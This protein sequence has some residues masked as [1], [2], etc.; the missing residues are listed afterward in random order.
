LDDQYSRPTR[1]VAVNSTESW[2]RDLTLDIADELRQR[3]AE[4]RFLCRSY[5][6]G[7]GADVETGTPSGRMQVEMALQFLSL[8]AGPANASSHASSRERRLVEQSRL[9]SAH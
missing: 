1:I 5:W 2:S 7:Q 8:V 4:R 9:S 6:R 3:F